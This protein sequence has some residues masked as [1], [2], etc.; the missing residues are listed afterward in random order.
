MTKTTNATNHRILVI[1]DNRAI[2]EDFKKIFGS[3]AEQESPLAESEAALFGDAPLPAP[4]HPV[5]EFDSAFQGQE[6]LALIQRALEEKCPYAM[7]FVDVRMPP[8]WDGIETIARICEKYPE[9][10]VVVCTAY[11]DYS[12]EEMV[13]KLGQSDR[14]VILK[15]PFDNIEVLQLATALTEKWCLYQHAK[16]KLDDLEQMVR[17]RTAALQ[18]ANSE[19]ASANQC[20]L[21]ESQRAKQLA[22]AALVASKVKSEFLAVMSHEIRTPMN[23]IIGMTGLLLDTS[24]DSEQRDFAETVKSSA[25]ILLNILDDILDFSKINA[26]KLALESIDFELRDAVG[27]AVN[28]MAER[29]RG[30]GIRL[31]CR[32]EPEIPARL[33]GDP[34]RLRQILL[35]LLSNAIKFTEAGEVAVEISRI[36]EAGG[37][38]D[39]RFAVRDTGIGISAEARRGLFEPF[40]QADSSMTRKFGGTGLGLAICRKLVDLM[41]GRVGVTS[42]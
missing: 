42:T 1:D 11:S 15:K 38:I 34:H 3:T 16:C 33:R 30:K 24:L 9:L 28:L 41:E 5:F 7:A 22:S 17:D 35:N 13:K 12:W 14:L 18:S 21:E 6:G 36:G 10:Q 23:G 27:Q 4:S 19:L 20:L 26:G 39:L 29:A 25:D 40:V 31:V 37:A 2:H 32:I 8:G